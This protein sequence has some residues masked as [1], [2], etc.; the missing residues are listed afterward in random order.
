MAFQMLSYSHLRPNSPYKDGLLHSLI[1]LSRCCN[2]WVTLLTP[3][4]SPPLYL[5]TKVCQTLIFNKRL[6]RVAEARLIF[7]LIQFQEAW[8]P[9]EVGML[10]AL[11]LLLID[12]K[13]CGMSFEILSVFF[14]IKHIFHSREIVLL[15]TEEDDT[16]ALKSPQFVHR[17]YS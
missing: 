1:L 6:L 15:P 2:V 8:N 12:E 3:A 16:I 13:V 11:E 17:L 4:I 14:L 10:I 7:K 9:A 5:P